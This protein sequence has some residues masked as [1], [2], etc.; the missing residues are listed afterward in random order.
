MTTTQ[1]HDALRLAIVP[2]APRIP[3]DLASLLAMAPMQHSLAA[4]GTLDLRMA[5]YIGAMITDT[6][7][8]ERAERA[9]SI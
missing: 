6:L 9:A 1:R 3:S 2:R 7:R 5:D 8:A 4:C